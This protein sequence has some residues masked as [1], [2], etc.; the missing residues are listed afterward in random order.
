MVFHPVML[1]GTESEL[2][3]NKSKMCQWY[4]VEVRGILG[5]GR[6][7]AQEIEILGRTPESVGRFCASWC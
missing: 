5:C 7:D 4:G 2:R 6:R 3:K 1:A